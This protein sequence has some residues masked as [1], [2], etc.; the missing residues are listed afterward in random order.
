VRNRYLKHAHVSDREFRQILKMYCAD[1][2]AL[3]A[4]KL[5]GLNKNTTHRLYGLLRARVLEMAKGEAA[6]FTGSVEVDESYFGPRRVRG[7][8]GRGSGRKVAVIGLLKRKGKVF[9]SPVMNCSKAE[10]IEVIRG[11]VLPRKSTIY[12]DGWRAYDGLVLEGYKH[13][14]IHHHE[15]EFASIV[16]STALSPSGATPNCAWPSFAAFAGSTSMTTSK[17]PNGA[18]IIA[19]ITSSTSSS[20]TSAA[21]L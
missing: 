9:C 10:L 11:Q 12:T 19:V 16:I 14:R 18:S 3:T 8:R 21:H 6:P 7:R 13:H 15:N 1:I 5:T 4:S 2:G 20:L 17:K